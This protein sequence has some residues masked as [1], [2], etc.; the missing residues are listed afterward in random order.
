MTVIG[1]HDVARASFGL[2]S[3]VF[4]SLGR[5]LLCLDENF[6]V[7]HASPGVRDLLGG[8]TFGPLE[9]RPVAD[10]L[11]KDLFGPDAPLRD[12][13]LAGERREG[14]RALL[15][16]AQGIRPLAI[17]A[18]PMNE[19]A[20]AACD[21][22]ARYLVLILPAEDDHFAAGA[23]P[24]VL[25]GLIA[26][27]TAM[28]RVFKLVENLQTSDA[29]VLLT[30]ERGTGKEVVA[31]A[32]HEHSPRRRGPFLTVNC[33]AL[34]A[35]LLDSELFGHVRGAFVGAVRDRVGR[36]ELASQGTLFLDE[37]NE[38]PLPMQTKLLRVL[39]ER[40]YERAGE[41]QTRTTDAR[42]I[43]A[44][45]VDLRDAVARGEFREDLYERLHIVPIEI[46]PLRAR[47]EDIEPLARLLLRRVGELHGRHLRFAPDVIR[48][49]LT[50][51]WPGNVQEL[52]GAIEYAFA[53]TKTTV[54]QPED[55]PV[56][57][58]GAAAEVAPKPEAAVLSEPQQLRI[59]LESHRWRREAT[60]QALGISRATLWRRMRE[61]GLL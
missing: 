30:G 38:L 58:I 2:V 61:F 46:P 29:P 53:V 43:A 7:L 3:A 48:L 51:P 40:A 21:P 41:L 27:S 34:P 57:I 20:A 37:V 1:E 16:T 36:F 18:A 32:I 4:T 47:R 13:L 49:F 15:H 44:T 31:R 6:R 24:T 52:E 45:N 10:L 60:A 14:W 22:R 35:E 9:R 28:S 54:I 12:A 26:R 19:E 25:S 11:G 56:E 8:E 23:G 50:Y 59:A 39:Q 42:V 55:L 5:S 17:S 33:A